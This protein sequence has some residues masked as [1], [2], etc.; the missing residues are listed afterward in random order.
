MKFPVQGTDFIG[1]LWKN[2]WADV[3]ILV[4]LMAITTLKTIVF[5]NKKNAF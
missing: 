5:Q 4:E 3:L 1:F 2:R